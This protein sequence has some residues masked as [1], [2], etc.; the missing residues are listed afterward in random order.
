MVLQ[1]G[2]TVPV[3][4]TAQEG[5]K[6]TVRIQDQEA[7]AATKHGRWMV[8]LKDLKA[9]GPFTM[10]IEGTNRIELTNV[11]VG[12]VWICSGQS[13]MQWPV[14]MSFQAKQ[15]L[16]RAK[17]SNIRL[18]T[19][20]RRGSPKPEAD[21]PFVPLPP[22][23]DSF[24]AN[25]QGIWLECTPASAEDFSAVAYYFGQEL[26][27][28][29]HVPVGLIHNSFGGT[30]AQAWTRREALAAVP[31]LKIY[32][33]QYHAA[34]GS[35]PNAVNKYAAAAEAYR[36][37]VE[38]AK[39]AG[40]APPAPPAVPI[41][42]GKSQSLASTLYN[43]MIAPL[44]PYAIK[45]AIWYQ[46]ESNGFA[47]EEA[48]RYRILFSTMIKNWREDWK[49]GDFPFLFVQ[50]APF[51]AGPQ[52]R[53]PEL[54]ESQLLTAKNLSRVGMAVITDLG[55]EKEG[56]PRRKQP[57]G[58]RL[59][60]AARALAYGENIV[61]SGPIYDR[62]RVEGSKVEISFKHVGGG[63]VARDGDLVGFT[64][65][66]PDKEFVKA[67]ARIEGDKVAVWSS[68]VSSP[69]AVRFGWENFPKPLLNLFNK[70]GLPA[71]PFRTDVANDK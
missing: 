29:L 52:A 27:E 16:G 45:G 38:K 60:L 46:G 69:L 54:R 1:Q 8:Q 18:F 43:A 37:G 12:E 49:Q 22:A 24:Q 51:N 3:W 61:Y 23:P 6:V 28:K 53:W 50:L 58:A 70:E 39:A 59:A 32:L 44:T 62:M 13:N 48:L 65:C 20:Q 7:S 68:A 71:S 26:Q 41:D 63:L 11:L 21:I 19:V 47:L 2:M 33:D 30:P 9:G 17:N 25:A 4:G 5:E 42:P 66:G 15:Y 67:E 40:K 55:D 31:E 35:Y 34:E 56:H 57:V 14:S 64:I 10:T 36:E